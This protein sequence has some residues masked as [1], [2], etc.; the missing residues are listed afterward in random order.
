MSLEP[1]AGLL[2]PLFAGET[3]RVVFADRSRLQAMLDFE[4]ALAVAEAAVGVIP[5]DAA[6]IVAKHCRAEAFDMAALGVATALAGNPA[7]PLVK[8]LTARVA[9]DDAAAARYVHWGSTSQDVIDTGLMLQLRSALTVIQG[10]VDRLIAALAQ[11]TALHRTTPLVGRTLLQHALP[12][13]FGLKLAGW[14]D[15]MLRHRARLAA[16]PE[17]V[18]ALQFGGASGT[19]AA[20]GDKGIAVGAALAVELD[21]PQ[22]NLPWHSHRDRLVEVAT[23]LG[24]LVGTLGKI[25]RDIVLSMQTEVAEIFEPAGVGKGGSSA[26]P[27][28]RNPVG[29]VVSQAAAIRVPGLVATM[30]AAMMQEH[31]R[32]AGGWHAEWEVLPEI[33]TLASGALVHTLTMVDGLE[34]DTVRMRRNLDATHGLI[35]AEA[36]T[37]ALGRHIGRSDAYALVEAACKR[38]V[39]EDRT[40]GA[41]LAGEPVVTAHLLPTDL[42]ELLEPANYLGSAFAFVDRALAA[43]HDKR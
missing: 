17:C 34:I 8:A 10:D 20:L 13:T 23:T 38:A 2:A 35:M 41:V 30:L 18:L 3:M 16:L 6:A 39:K 21:L 5:R 37:A 33:L 19:L 4:A 43:V 32:A 1:P 36:A 42:D 7:I 11:Q 9:L 22:P 14:L 25:G 27:H 28:K 29:S 40:L 15:A 31:E 12:I 26:L 24:L